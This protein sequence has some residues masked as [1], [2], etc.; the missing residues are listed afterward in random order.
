MKLATQNSRA[1]THFPAG[2]CSSQI[3][4]IPIQFSSP[5]HNAFFLFSTLALP[6]YWFGYGLTWI[7]STSYSSIRFSDSFP[8]LSILLHSKFLYSLILN[9]FMIMIYDKFNSIPVIVINVKCYSPTLLLS[10]MSGLGDMYYF[11]YIRY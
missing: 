10:N 8:V 11:G 7:I 4:M 6:L 5:V 2:S 9:Q 1:T 3:C